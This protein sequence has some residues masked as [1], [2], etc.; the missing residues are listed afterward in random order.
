[1]SRQKTGVLPPTHGLGLPG[2]ELDSRCA[3]LDHVLGQGRPQPALRHAISNTFAFG[4][5]NAS[6]VFSR[7]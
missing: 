5:T 4:G 2:S 1:M 7:A 6:L 3:G